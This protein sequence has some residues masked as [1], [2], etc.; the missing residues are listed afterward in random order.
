MAT[1][2]LDRNRFLLVL[3]A[4]LAEIGVSGKAGG[5]SEAQ[6]PRVPEGAPEVA[7]GDEL[8]SF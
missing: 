5:T 4:P 6:S 7:A 3:A 2:Q 1:V 8:E